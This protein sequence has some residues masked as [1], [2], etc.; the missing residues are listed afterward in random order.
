[1]I[2]EK[3]GIAYRLSK[4]DQNAEVFKSKDKM[5]EITIPKFIENQS[6]L[7]KVVQISSESFLS[8]TIELFKMFN[9]ENITISQKSFENCNSLK[10][11]II[12]TKEVIHI[13]ENN[14]SKL[15]N[16]E[17][18]CMKGKQVIIDKNCFNECFTSKLFTEKKLIRI[19]GTNNI[20]I[21]N[22]CFKKL[23]FLDQIELKSS[24][25]IIG[26]DCFDECR[27]LS[28]FIISESY[29]FSLGK[30]QFKKCLN[31]QNIKLESAKI[32]LATHCFSLS[33][34]TKVEI[35]C[36]EITI[37][38]FG[39]SD[40]ISIIEFSIRMSNN[41]VIKANTFTG[42]HNLKNIS[43]ISK[44]SLSIDNSS[45]INLESLEKISIKCPTIFI[46]QC[47]FMNCKS[48]SSIEFDDVIEYKI[49]DHAFSQC[50]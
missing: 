26:D 32:E 35:F 23:D 3:N 7:Y 19:E 17:L 27:Y 42:C 28:S 10:T 34:L 9:D 33:N 24:K 48:L 18:I 39:F 40:L 50:E 29:E 36:D 4:D 47:C 13:E 16:L 41:V 45:F 30:N 15:P 20:S 37:D 49:S 1:M 38:K 31:F 2:I 43:I 14:Y 11:I 44:K 21:G 8:S 12:E 5:K 46:G 22:A 6:K 25:I